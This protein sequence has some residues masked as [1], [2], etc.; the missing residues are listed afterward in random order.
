M[1]GRTGRVISRPSASHEH[2]AAQIDGETLDAVIQENAS[3]VIGDIALCHAPEIEHRLGVVYRQRR[4]GG[5]T[6]EVD[7]GA[8]QVRQRA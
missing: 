8:P 5:G 7:V 6:A 1:H 2:I 4:R 3:Q